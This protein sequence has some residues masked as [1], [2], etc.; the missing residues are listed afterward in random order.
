MKGIKVAK[1]PRMQVYCALWHHSHGIDI[2][3]NETEKGCDMDICNSVVPF[4]SD[5]KVQA[6]MDRLMKKGKYHEAISLW[7]NANGTDD[8]QEWIEYRGCLEIRG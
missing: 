3:L 5:D 1:Q 7:T 8:A 4:V 2:F 6:K